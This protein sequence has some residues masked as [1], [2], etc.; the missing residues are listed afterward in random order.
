MTPL[1][2]SETA[3]LV[4]DASQGVEAQS[5]ANCYTAIEQGVEVL[6]VINK[7]DLPSADPDRS[8][9][10]YGNADTNT[11]WRPT[12]GKSQVE[13]RRG[14]I[15]VGSREFAG[16]NLGCLAVMPRTASPEINLEVGV[17]GGTGAAGLRL[18]QG[19]PYFL[20]GV[21]YPDCF[22]AGREML[23]KGAAGVRAAGFFGNDWT[24]EH[25]DFAWA[26]PAAR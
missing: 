5:V 26:G 10:L 9:V 17:V 22:V 15:T 8:V 7:I 4:V 18:T 3:L 20:S 2:L 24:V 13:V 11:A 25:G 14:A 19:L 21:G 16:S 12:L 6:P 1:R 23:E